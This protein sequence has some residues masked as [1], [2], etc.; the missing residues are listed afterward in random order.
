MG[1]SNFDI[2]V[3]WNDRY[4]YQYNDPFYP[5]YRE[6]NNQ[7][8]VEYVEFLRFFVF[9]HLPFTDSRESTSRQRYPSLDR[10]PR[11]SQQ[12]VKALQK[13]LRYPKLG[14][15]TPVLSW[16]IDALKYL[17]EQLNKDGRKRS[18]FGEIFDLLKLPPFFDPTRS[19][20][21]M[22]TYRLKNKKTLSRLERNLL[23]VAEYLQE[24]PPGERGRPHQRQEKL[25]A[26]ALT[27]LLRR[28]I[29]E[30]K[31]PLVRKCLNKHFE[32]EFSYGSLRTYRP[33]KA[34]AK[35]LRVINSI[36]EN[37]HKVSSLLP[38]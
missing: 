24:K 29:R 1:R 3:W 23:D 13:L 12:A 6:L 33:S 11:D 5:L 8:D 15:L 21:V 38:A 17:E 16:V 22:A 37:R 25:F 30:P 26:L 31:Y 28:R 35:I 9:P 36:A 7:H 10:L 4:F 2:N 19:L 20:P 27:Q 32:R 14:K 18:T 34:D